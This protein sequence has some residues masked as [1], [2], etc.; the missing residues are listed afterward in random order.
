MK[1]GVMPKYFCNSVPEWLM[2]LEKIQNELNTFGFTVE[3]I[4][5]E[6]LDG[7][8]SIP[9][10]REMP[11]DVIPNSSEVD[12]LR[13][14][15]VRQSLSLMFAKGFVLRPEKGCEEYSLTDMGRDVNISR[16]MEAY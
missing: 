14:K 10:C 3:E 4:L 6:G 8:H 12:N 13:R 11:G 9:L 1:E 5:E 7:R 16:L 2:L 15:R